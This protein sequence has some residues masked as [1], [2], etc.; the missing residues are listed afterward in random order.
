MS[1]TKK[2]PDAAVRQG[3]VGEAPFRPADNIAAGQLAP[4][5]LHYGTGLRRMEQACAECEVAYQ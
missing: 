4:A 5:F 1:L 3:G 2:R